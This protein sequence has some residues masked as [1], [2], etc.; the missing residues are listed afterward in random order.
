[1]TLGIDTV[2][3]AIE[4]AFICIGGIAIIFAGF[5][6]VLNKK[7]HYFV[8]INNCMNKFQEN[9]I[10]DNEFTDQHRKY[11]DLVNEELFYIENKSLLSG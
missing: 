8:V 9:F 7:Q 6:Y 11:L 4:V 2:K 5:T 3:D 10:V 1:M